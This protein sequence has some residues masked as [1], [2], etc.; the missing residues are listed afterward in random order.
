MKNVE[1]IE[2]KCSGRRIPE[3]E[4][5]ESCWLKNPANK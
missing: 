2:K 1:K 5:L 3:K 4:H